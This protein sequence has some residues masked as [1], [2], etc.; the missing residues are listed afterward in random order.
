M[1]R[2]GS[3]VLGLGV[4]FALMWIFD[5]VHEI[6]HALAASV[7]GRSVYSITMN[8]CQVEDPTA[9]IALSGFWFSWIVFSIIAQKS[10]TP[11]LK[12]GLSAYAMINVLAGLVSSD[13]QF[14]G[15][16]SA[17]WY[18]VGISSYL[19]MAFASILMIGAGFIQTSPAPA[20]ARSLPSP[21]LVRRSGTR[22]PDSAVRRMSLRANSVHS[23]IDRM[24]ARSPALRSLR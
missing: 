20:K 2:L 12:I 23:Q 14:A 3:L 17:V 1:K 16:E 18:M 19:G 9:F 5:P 15:A 8:T 22:T 7:T 11:Y 10:K 21:S 4:G 6:G 13:L 24:I